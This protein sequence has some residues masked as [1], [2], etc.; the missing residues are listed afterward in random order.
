MVEPMNRNSDKKVG[1]LRPFTVASVLSLA[2]M[3]CGGGTTN[4]TR[5]PSTTASTITSFAPSSARAGV[6]TQFTVVGTN[7]PTTAVVELP[8]GTCASPTNTTINGFLVQCTPGGSLGAVT[9]IVNNNTAA[10]GGYWI[11]QQTVTITAGV[12]GVSLLNDTGI[13]ANQCYG[14]GSDALISCTSAAAVALNA[15]QDGMMGRDVTNPDGIDGW[16]G[17]SYS[18]STTTT[19][20]ITPTSTTTATT[21]NPNC[22]KD[23]VT[24]LTWQRASTTLTSLTAA[25]L[26]TEAT[27]LRDA[28]NFAVLC[29]FSDWRLPTPSELQSLVNYGQS[30]ASPAIDLNWFS[31]TLSAEYFTDTRYRFGSGL[32]LWGVNFANGSVGDSFAQQLRLVR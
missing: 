13:T 22:I 29:G 8:G 20:T 24:G 4:T 16:L 26:S 11:G 28:A 31:T 3:A 1:T 23:N 10:N 9:S 6:A 32:H 27:G 15:Q 5:T 30:N 14:A 18:I 7:I 17:S 21:T 19:T 25:T 2:L 12:T